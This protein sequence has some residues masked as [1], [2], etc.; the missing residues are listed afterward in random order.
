[1][2][3]SLSDD[4]NGNLQSVININVKLLH[5]YSLHDNNFSISVSS[6][7]CST[8]QSYATSHLSLISKIHNKAIPH[9]H[10]VSP[11]TESS[12]GNICTRLPY[13]TDGQGAIETTS[14]NRTRRLFRTTRFMRIFSSGQ[15]SSES[16]MH[17]V[18]LR[19]FPFRSTVSPRN[20]CNC[21]I[22]AYESTQC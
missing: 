9:T 11:S 19:R 16:T 1:M 8:C 17:T 2:N 3:W 4:A 5:K 10:P 20:N 13:L 18:S 14:D 22:L 21:S 6:V 7:H 15:L 12:I